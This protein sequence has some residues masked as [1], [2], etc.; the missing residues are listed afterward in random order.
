MTKRHLEAATPEARAKMRKQLGTLKQLTVQP[1]TRARYSQSLQSFFKFL[2]SINRVLPS[3]AVELDLVVSDYL[4][5]LWAEGEGRSAGSNILAALQDFSTTVERQAP[6]KLE[7][8]ESL[9]SQ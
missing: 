5:Q 2:K 1:T 7:T 6:A 4:E 9:G 8:H 3:T